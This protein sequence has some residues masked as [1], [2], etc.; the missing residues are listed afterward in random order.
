[1]ANRSG[2]A[3]L[4]SDDP[5][6]SMNSAAA[7]C[8]CLFS[9]VTSAFAE[10]TEEQVA[11][12]DK[13]QKVADGLGYQKGDITLKNGLAKI[14]LTPYFMYLDPKDTGT[15]LS[16]IWGNPPVNDTLGMLVPANVS[17]ASRDGWGIIITYQEDGYVKD[18]DAAKMDY[19]K[20]LKQMQTAM[21]DSN[22]ERTKE[23]YPAME[24]VG[25]ATPPRYD[26]ATH[27]MYWAKELTVGGGDEN[28]LN[29]NIRML[30]RRGVLVLNAVAAMSQLQEI[31]SAT[32]GVL[33][34]VN[35]QDGNRYTDFNS[36]TD[37]VAAYGLAAL[38][39]G[40][41]AAKVGL[42]KG[43]IVA[44]IAAKKL[45]IVGCVAVAG[46]LKRIFGKKSQSA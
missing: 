11:L 9:I 8:L 18:N 29:Y 28:T 24:L 5:F 20:L 4:R 17:V 43:L 36:S 44:L 22:A 26:Q 34:M 2:A 3:L 35:F 23:G 25:W 41:V 27:K 6:S 7:F 13:L 16:T 12:H 31:E 15:V 21:H 45:V 14:H 1:M 38:L 32:P 19:P 46:F 33:A 10:P 39:V 40:G 42:F 37:K 30:G